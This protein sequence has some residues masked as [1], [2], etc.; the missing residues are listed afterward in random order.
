MIRYLEYIYHQ[1]EISIWYRPFMPHR[2]IDSLSEK[3]F[4]T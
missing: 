3:A 1:Q 2:M 4:L